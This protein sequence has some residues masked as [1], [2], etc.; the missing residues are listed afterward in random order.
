MDALKIRITSPVD[1]A[2]VIASARAPA[3][4]TF[5][6]ELMSRPSAL[7]AVPLY[8]RWYSSLNRRASKG[9]YSLNQQ[10]LTSATSEHREDDL[11][12]GSQV[13]GF[14]A[15]DQL[16]ESDPEIQAIRH[17]A[18]AGGDRQQPQPPSQPCVIH[19][20][21]ATI[22]DLPAEVPRQG[23]VLKAEA[24]DAWKEP[25][26]QAVNQLRY[27]WI[28]SPAP[29]P[30]GWSPPP[31]GL[32]PNRPSRLTY[33]HDP[34]VQASSWRFV[35][36]A[37]PQKPALLVFTPALPPEAI[38]PYTITLEVADQRNPVPA[39]RATDVRI[40]DLLA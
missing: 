13:I 3:P 28:L 26:Y 20:L 2:V 33:V 18:Y 5:K 11:P 15:T 34:S 35:A 29:P 32:P 21:R 22:F 31:Q 37:N 14:A 8:F 12:L 36:R 6:G 16:G 9:R 38:G 1:D 19:V 23:L 30:P 10:A 25:S 4:V 17:G 27:S 24:P 7:A 40:I 39:R